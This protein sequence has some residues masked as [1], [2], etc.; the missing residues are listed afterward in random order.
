MGRRDMNIHRRRIVAG[1][2]RRDRLGASL[3]VESLE[4]RLL[5]AAPH[6]DDC[7]APVP[8]AELLGAGPLAAISLDGREGDDQTSIIY[9]AATGGVSVDVAVGVELTSVNLVSAAGIFTGDP[10]ENLGG[11]FDIDNDATVF[12]AT[13]GTSFGSIGFGNVA[14]PYL[15]VVFLINDLS[16]DGS[17]LGSDQGLGD[18]DFIYIPPLLHTLADA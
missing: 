12:K 5:L 10:A 4:P 11:P 13:F 16:V 1:N 3:R 2:L 18:V 8:R 6:M 7:M 15:D 17:V 9:D 14:Q